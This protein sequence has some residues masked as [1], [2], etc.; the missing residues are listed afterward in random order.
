VNASG[1]F[2]FESEHVGG[3][4]VARLGGEFD[5]STSPAL[6]DN[7]ADLCD[8]GRSVVLDLHAVTFADSTTLGVFVA[9]YKRLRE[10][11]RVL[12]LAN[13]SPSISQILE[14]TQLDT[15]IP[16]CG[17]VDQAVAE[18]AKRQ[19]DATTNDAGRSS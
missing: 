6:R 17:S 15:V 1:A 14:I 2:A 3:V 4:V 8:A 18:A 11:H 9:T 7:L 5:L 19:L 12:V 13:V 10:R 16:V